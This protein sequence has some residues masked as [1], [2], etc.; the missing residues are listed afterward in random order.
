MVTQSYTSEDMISLARMVGGGQLRGKFSERAMYY[1]KPNTGSEAGWIVVAG[2]NPERQNQLM[3]RGFI[4]LQQ[5]GFTSPQDVPHED[6]HYRYWYGI[7]SKPGGPAEFPVD[8]LIAY[9]WYDPRFCPVPGVRFPQ[10]AGV[11]IE[12][13]DCPDCEEKR[14]HKSNHLAR[15]LF[16]THGWDR[17]DIIAW[18]KE[19]GID[20]RKEMANG[21]RVRRTV[22]YEAAEPEPEP[23]VAYNVKA[24]RL[25]GRRRSVAEEAE[26]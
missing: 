15:H 1:R 3:L 10:L 20:F 17:A 23:E 2:T 22:S 16:V 4:P 5:Y 9:R 24:V 25:P 21:G 19:V 12:E 18:G 26:A 8:Q 6:A 7:L 11:E 13:F 14:Y